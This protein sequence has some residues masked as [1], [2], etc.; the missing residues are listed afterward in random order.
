[1]IQNFPIYEIT[2][3]T[4]TDY[5]DKLACIAWFAGCNMRCT[6]CYNP[7]I[8]LGCGKV[9]EDEFYAFLRSRVGK[10]EAVVF[11]GGE[12][13]CARDFLQILQT[14]KN[15]G[16]LI[17][18]DTNGSNP[19]IIQNAVNLGLVDFISLDFKADE[20]KFYEITKSNFY[21]NFLQNLRFLIEANFDFEVRT[22][23]HGD[24]LSED[25]ISNMVQ[26]L[27]KQGYRGTYYL[28]NFLATEQ[29]LGNI[30][31]PKHSFEPTKIKSVLKIGLR[32]F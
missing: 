16:Y 30:V 24:L 3:F 13:T 25:E 12:C 21:E 15:L 31:Q 22:T 27:H 8:V 17:K 1:M 9:S 14:T 19:K 32:N 5:P 6:Y 2:P 28:Q 20:A 18:I 23:V 7:S 4:M 10:L 26:I 11:S 29:N